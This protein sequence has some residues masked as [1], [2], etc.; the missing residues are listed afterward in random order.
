VLSKQGHRTGRGNRFTAER[1]RA[2]RS[3]YGIPS[4]PAKGAESPPTYNVAQAARRLE[5]STA[6]IHRWL[7]L[8]L[9]KG[10][11]VTPH[12]PWI[13]HIS[14]EDE[15]RLRDAGTGAGLSAGDLARSLG[16]PKE[17]VL[18]KIRSGE[19]AVRRVQDGRRSRWIV[20]AA[21]LSASEQRQGMLFEYD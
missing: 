16:L 11:Q 17:L 13:I 10:T 1:V 12:A 6:T 21:P 3:H 14:P 15:V 20:D 5:V 18:E 8:G 19:M 2:L 4:C 7:D 9:L